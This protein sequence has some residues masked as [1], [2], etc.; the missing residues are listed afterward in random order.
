MSPRL[1]YKPKKL[2][3]AHADIVAVANLILAEYAEQGYDL[4]LRQLYYQYVSRGYIANSDREYKRLGSIINDARMAG[5]IDWKQIVDRTRYIREVPSWSSPGA[6]V[7]GAANGY[8]RDLWEDQDTRVEVWVEKDAVVGVIE[9]ACEDLRVPFLSCRGYTSASEMWGASRR[10][11]GYFDKGKRVKI[12]HL[13]DH[14][15]SG[16]DMSRDI[17]H[18]LFLFLAVDHHRNRMEGSGTDSNA[19]VDYVAENFSL[20]RLA[21]NWDQVEQYEPP[22]NP[23]KLTDSRG[24]GYVEQY[25]HE[26]WE[27]DALE[28]TV[29]GQLI[30]DA[31]DEVRD[32][33]RWEVAAEQEDRERETLELAAGRWGEIAAFLG[34]D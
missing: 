31:V 4:T 16:I 18:R 8:Q 26:S 23:A 14:D 34:E 24:A 7:Q 29:I 10:F 17:E 9:R 2:S 32:V 30:E 28:P 3:Q 27:L 19:S 1:I 6:I 15:P 12:L 11:L 25:G 21:L 33:D 22:P 13:G 5:Y 20:D